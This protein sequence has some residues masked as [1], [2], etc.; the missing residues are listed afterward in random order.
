[1]NL[2]K[3]PALRLAFVPGVIEA[4]FDAGIASVLF[5]MPY[6]LALA[7]GFILKAV[8][9]GLVVPAMFVLQKEGWGADKGIPSTVVIAAS[10]D[11]IIAI[12]GF[13]IFINIAI[14]GGKDAAWQIA[15][16]PL[17]VRRLWAAA[18]GFALA[19]TGCLCLL[20]LSAYPV[21]SAMRSSSTFARWHA[22]PPPVHPAR[23]CS[24]LQEASLRAPCWAAPRSGTTSTSA[25]LAST[26]L[27]G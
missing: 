16:G 26:A 18:W 4:V 8:G 14:A 17:Q 23:C 10:F 27:V 21:A 20:S 24:A 19:V 2:Y 12:T 7:M 9:P 22:S 25:S 15:S 3:W 1:M 11:D 13:S 6:T 5:S